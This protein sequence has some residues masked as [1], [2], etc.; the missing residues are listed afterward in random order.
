V[1][2]PN[3]Q[4]ARPELYPPIGSKHELAERISELSRRK[5]CPRYTHE[6]LMTRGSSNTSLWTDN[7]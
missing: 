1:D 4:P 5:G 7:I 3:E 6:L 2:N